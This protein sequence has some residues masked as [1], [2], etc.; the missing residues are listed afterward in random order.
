SALRRMRM[1]SRHYEKNKHGEESCAMP[2]MWFIS[3]CEK[4]LQCEEKEILHVRTAHVNSLRI[5]R[6]KQYLMLN[7]ACVDKLL[8]E[9]ISLAG[10]ARAVSISKRWLQEYVKK[11]EM[12]SKKRLSI[13][14]ATEKS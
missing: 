1:S 11:K 12:K 8:V 2:K 4:W 5:L 9:R 7:G 10:I 14:P 6:T 13:C 3:H